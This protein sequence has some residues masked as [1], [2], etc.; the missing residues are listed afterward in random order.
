MSYR[1]QFRL[2][3]Y[4]VPQ[5]SHD[6]VETDLPHLLPFSDKPV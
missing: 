1:D 6:Y 3:E 2:R 4:R 5:K